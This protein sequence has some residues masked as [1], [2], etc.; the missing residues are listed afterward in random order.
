MPGPTPHPEVN[1][2]LAKLPVA[3]RAALGSELR[4][5]Y[6]TGSFAAGDFDEHSDI[7]VVVVTRREIDDATFRTLSGMHETL[8]RLES[9]WA[10]QLEAAYAAPGTLRREGRIG[11]TLP[12]VERG[13]GQRLKRSAYDESWLVQ[14]HELRARAIPLAGPP[15]AE[16]VDPV[17]RDTLRQAMRVKLRGWAQQLSDDPSPLARRGYQSYVVLSLCRILYTLEHGDVVSKGAAACWAR[18]TTDARWHPVIDRAWEGRG[19]PADTATPEERDATLA[20]F[21]EAASTVLG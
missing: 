6:L 8:A 13:A 19:R 7:D 12:N 20:M 2:V 15:A 14:C 18:A 1:V 5:I 3:L 4:A 16:L 9:R 17:T 21:R 10:I 11:P